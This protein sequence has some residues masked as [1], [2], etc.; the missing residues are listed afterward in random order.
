MNNNYSCPKELLEEKFCDPLSFNLA[1]VR[2]CVTLKKRDA[3]V[4]MGAS[5]RNKLSTPGVTHEG[6]QAGK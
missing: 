2:M 6:R 4:A 3:T 1:S 5:P